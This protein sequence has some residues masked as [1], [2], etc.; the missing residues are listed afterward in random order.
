MLITDD[1]S[2]LLGEEFPG[3]GGGSVE[4]GVQLSRRGAPARS[5]PPA[6]AWQPCSIVGD[7]AVGAV[8]VDVERHAAPGLVVRALELVKALVIGKQTIGQ[9]GQAGGPVPVVALR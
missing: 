1:Y 8:A 3:G 2:A 9:A 6:R 5:R 7:R 4:L